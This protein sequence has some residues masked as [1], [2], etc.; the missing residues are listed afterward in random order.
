M[1]IYYRETTFQ[2][3]KY[4]FEL[5]ERQGNVSEACRR[6]KVSRKTYYRWKP[7]YE[8]DGVEGLCEPRS[9]VVH[10]PRTID[11]QIERRIIEL[12]RKH[13]NWGKKRIAQWIWKEHDWERVVAIE[14]VRNILD[15]HGLWNPVR[16]GKKNKNNRGITADNPNKTIN[17]DLCFAHESEIRIPNLSAFF[18]QMD[19]FCNKTAENE[20]QTPRMSGLD[21]FSDNGLSYDEMDAY[22]LMKKNGEEKGE[23][24]K[25]RADIEG[26]EIK[27]DLNE[28]IG[29]LR[30]WRRRIRI[31][32]DKEDE[33]WRKYR[34]KRVE[35][36]KRWEE[37]SKEEKKEFKVEKERGD[38]E[39]RR[40]KPERKESKAKRE[41]EDEEWRS[42]R[43]NL[44]E[45]I[46]VV[47]PSL[48]AILVI[49]DNCT[50]RC[51]RLP[52]LLKGRKVTADDVIK[53]LENVLPPQLRYIIS[54]NGKQFIAEA[55]Q[56]LCTDKR[57]AHVRITPYRPATNGIAERFIQRLKGMLVER[58]WMN[59]E[60]LR[61]VLETV[62]NEYN[63]AP[64]QGLDGLSPNE[65]ERRLRCVSSG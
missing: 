50:R 9:H 58:E 59:A 18:Q 25:E 47:V 36:N 35:R 33:D 27:A 29:N 52:V 38:E 10:N 53:A 49:I 57:I 15:R 4:L 34:K 44:L 3:R 13:P 55:F 7:R 56:K 46:N 43:K 22:V 1:A 42:K 14:T 37:L 48:I 28:A 45:R 40:K 8:K 31:E 32:R 54:D 30:V 51:L 64:H 12:R 16:R 62:V 39:W 65:Y 60:E 6:A 26:R 20:S 63:D 24:R 2:Q 5:V 17:I 23:T 11:P 41:K 19:G 61:M 21:V